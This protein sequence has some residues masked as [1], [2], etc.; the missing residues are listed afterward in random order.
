MDVRCW[1]LT[2][3]LKFMHFMHGLFFV[4]HASNIPMVVR[5]GVAKDEIVSPIWPLW[6]TFE[7]LAALLP[8]Q[9]Q[10]LGYCTSFQIVDLCAFLYI[11]GSHDADRWCHAPSLNT[12]GCHAIT[13]RW[14]RGC[15]SSSAVGG[16]F[17]AGEPVVAAARSC[18][19]SCH[20]ASKLWHLRERSWAAASR[21]SRSHF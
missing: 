15:A 19:D 4:K 10:L 8:H 9:H 11:C 5:T 20:I 18:T 7:R 1:I 6:D 12:S 3:I 16:D 17:L 14:N 21:A 2:V 13:A